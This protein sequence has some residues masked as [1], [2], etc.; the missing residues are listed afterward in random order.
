MNKTLTILVFCLLCGVTPLSAQTEVTA[1]AADQ[2]A[3]AVH[4]DSVDLPEGLRIDADDLLR[5]GNNRTL[6][7]ATGAAVVRNLTFT[8]EQLAERLSRIPT[9]IDLPLNEITKEYINTY[10]RRTNSVGVM[11]G[12]SNFYMPAFEEALERY[13]LPLELRYL[14]VIE[15]ALRPTA[16]SRAGAVGLWQIMLITARQY[17]LEVN[18][19]VDERRDLLKS[20]DAAARL[21]RDLYDRFGD[22]GLAIA[23]YNCGPGNIAKAMQRAG[24]GEQHDFWSL[25]GYLPRE[26]RGYLPAFIAATYIMNYYC[27]H[28]VVP[29]HA[30]LPAESDTVM[31]RRKVTFKQIADVCSNL[32]IETLRVLNP[33]YRRDIVPADYALRL[34]MTSIEEFV[35]KEDSIYAGAP[36][37]QTKIVTPE[38]VKKKESKKKSAAKGKTVTVRKGDSL[39]TIARRNG[40]TVAKLRKLNGLKGNNIRAGQKLKVR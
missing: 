14:P 34:P 29:M 25:Y 22:W 30:S 2:T 32:N 1:V 31:V 26:T 4:L 23:A 3:T 21:L 24:E 36:V 37:K 16:T 38:E 8:D 9:T 15:S 13:D 20:S 39:S 12:S 7:Q 18:T 40:T 17:G 10:I 28:G 19:L 5:D 33:Q 11:L 35:A 6:T 27:D